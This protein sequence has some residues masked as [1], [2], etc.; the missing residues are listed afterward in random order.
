[1]QADNTH[2]TCTNA[3]AAAYN[4]GILYLNATSYHLSRYKKRPNPC[5][6]AT[7]R[8]WLIEMSMSQLH[9]RLIH[10]SAISA[11][12]C[13]IQLR[14]CR[15]IENFRLAQPTAENV[16]RC[17]QCELALRE[18]MFGCFVFAKLGC[19]TKNI[20]SCLKCRYIGNFL[21]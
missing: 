1:M 20:I 14:F 5:K 21:S 6:R 10:I 16:D 12:V 11:C 9:F 17:V 18:R 13:G 4:F 3:S 19:F 15:E 7:Q 8:S 2:C